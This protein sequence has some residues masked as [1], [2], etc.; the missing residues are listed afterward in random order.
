MEYEIVQDSGGAASTSGSAGSQKLVLQLRPGEQAT[1]QVSVNDVVATEYL[2][3]GELQEAGAARKRMQEAEM[4]AFEEERDREAKK[5]RTQC[6]Y[7]TADAEVRPWYNRWVGQLIT[8]ED[9]QS[10]VGRDMAEFIRAAALVDPADT[11]IL[12]PDE[13]SGSDGGHNIPATMPYDPDEAET[14]PL[15]IFPE[16]PGRRRRE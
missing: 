16:S 6:A 2:Y 12:I 9:L 8:W 10:A 3:Q 14:V 7:N 11:Q 15:G 5:P 4:A 1:L 13:Q